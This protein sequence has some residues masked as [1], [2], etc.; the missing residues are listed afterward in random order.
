[1][2]HPRLLNTHR[3][4]SPLE[5]ARDAVRKVPWRKGPDLDLVARGLVISLSF[6]MENKP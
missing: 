1:M 4:H 6:E 3:R 5:H 2:N